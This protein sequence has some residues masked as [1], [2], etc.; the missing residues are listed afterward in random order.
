MNNLTH[1]T[2]TKGAQRWQYLGLK[3]S[4]T[5]TTQWKPEMFFA[6]L[7]K[8]EETHKIESDLENMDYNQH[9][10]TQGTS[11]HT[12]LPEKKQKVHKNGT[13]KLTSKLP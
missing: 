5:Q 8:L 4:R 11:I 12:S 13:S 6:I 1:R 3:R 7:Q 2:P 9:P 10:H